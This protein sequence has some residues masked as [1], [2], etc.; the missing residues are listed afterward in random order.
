MST[1]VWT[2]AFFER[3]TLKAMGLRIQLG[4]APGSRCLNPKKTNERDDFT[5]IHTN[6][7]HAVSVDFCGCEGTGRKSRPIQLMRAGWYPATGLQ[8]KTAATFHC[9][10]MFHLLSFESKCSAYEYYKSLARATDNTGMETIKV[11]RLSL[12]NVQRLTDLLLSI[13]TQSS[14]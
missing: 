9:L 7:I 12:D 14:S 10:E 4:H 2:G 6:G 8:P 5:V 3:T 13:G 1:K 11:S